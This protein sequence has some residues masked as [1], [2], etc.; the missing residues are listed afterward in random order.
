M[1]CV[2]L[3]T[4]CYVPPD[5]HI[6]HVT[7]EVVETKDAPEAMKPLAEFSRMDL[8]LKVNVTT[9]EDIMAVWTAEANKRHIVFDN[10]TRLYIHP[11]YQYDDRALYTDIVERLA[12]PD[13][14]TINPVPL[15]RPLYNK[16]PVYWMDIP[17]TPDIEKN[18]AYKMAGITD[19]GITYT[20]FLPLRAVYPKGNDTI[21]FTRTQYLAKSG[22][23]VIGYAK[24]EVYNL[25]HYPAGLNC[26]FSMQ[27]DTPE[28]VSF[29]ASPSDIIIPRE[30]IV[31]ALHK[32]G[33]AAN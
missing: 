20:F 14:I 26:R 9:K 4:G 7:Q 17:V 32:A 1:G 2:L 29:K 15:P 3:L 13:I 28:Y 21:Q 8:L 11:G 18:P 10:N 27:S 31:E 5:Y 24:N 19:K 30:R 6:T 22:K 16:L 23:I 25:M 33:L 12:N